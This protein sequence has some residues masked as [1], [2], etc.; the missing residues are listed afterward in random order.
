VLLL[1]RK[2]FLCHVISMS[3]GTWFVE[4]EQASH[5]GC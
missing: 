4:V 2:F 3:V 1:E 5:R